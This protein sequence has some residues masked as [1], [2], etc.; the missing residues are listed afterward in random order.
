MNITLPLSDVVLVL[1][2]WASCWVWI[3]N[4]VKLLRAKGNT[5]SEIFRIALGGVLIL[6]PLCGLVI[7][8][9]G[10]RPVWRATAAAMMMVGFVSAVYG[11]IKNWREKE[12]GQLAISVVALVVLVVIWFNGST[13][14]VKA[15]GFF[16]TLWAAI[17]DPF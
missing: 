9:F 15:P 1:I 5:F 10:G 4:N 11:T 12:Y 8:L 17:T 14:A 6:M 2:Y 13:S 3:V 7:A 16:K